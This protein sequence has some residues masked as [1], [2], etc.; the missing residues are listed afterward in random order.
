M[1]AH[2]ER[3]IQT[4]KHG[5]LNKFAIVGSR[6]LNDINSEFQ[7]HNDRERPHD[8]RGS[9]PP[10]PFDIPNAPRAERPDVVAH[11]RLG[12]QLTSYSQRT[13]RELSRE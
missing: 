1:R 11:S 2:V 12:G 7:V 4:L 13:A 6:H 5:C 8:A 10:D 9:P 3:F